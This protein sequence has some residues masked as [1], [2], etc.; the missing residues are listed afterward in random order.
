VIDSVG[1]ILP[2]G[3]IGQIA[4][5]RPHPVMMLRYWNNEQ[6]TADKFIGDWLV[7]GDLGRVD[8]EGYFWFCGRA[9]DVITSS[10]YRI[11]PGEI[12]DA[13]LRHPAVAM[14]AVIGVPDP[15]RTEAIK[16][17]IVLAKGCESS[18]VL[19]ESIRE[20]V[21]SRLARHECP[22]EIEFIDSMPMTTTGKLR[23]G[24]LREAE[25]ARRVARSS[26]TT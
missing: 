9:D 7:T 17:F 5:R 10:G 1:N 14:A 15:I 12:E 22:R 11:G 19:A 4:F 24:A 25:R 16:A 3:E 2:P 20:T 18:G 8:E 13:L 23:R 26:P 21:R 6:A